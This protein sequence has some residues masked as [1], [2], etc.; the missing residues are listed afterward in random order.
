[1]PLPSGRAPLAL[2]ELPPRAVSATLASHPS[3][4]SG[5]P[6]TP[7]RVF[8]G[9][10][11]VAGLLQNLSLS[12]LP[13]AVGAQQRSDSAAYGSPGAGMLP[14]DAGSSR[15]G[16]SFLQPNRSATPQTGS[17]PSLTPGA[18][19]TPGAPATTP[20][21][22]LAPMTAQ[23]ASLSRLFNVMAKASVGSASPSSQGPGGEV[24]YFTYQPHKKG[25]QGAGQGQGQ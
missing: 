17:N 21:G 4:A 7:G 20:G 9:R 6:S 18:L 10:E 12:S 5:S 8:S 24:D 13:A 16:D 22:S 3:P 19:L 25:G 11:H 23:A 2:G 14:V 15:S 1:M